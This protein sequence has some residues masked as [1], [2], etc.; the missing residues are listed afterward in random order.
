MELIVLYVVVL[1]M[2]GLLQLQQVDEFDLDVRELV[3]LLVGSWWFGKLNVCKG[4]EK[5]GLLGNGS[6]KVNALDGIPQMI[7]QYIGVPRTPGASPGGPP[8]SP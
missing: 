6:R 8:P 7:L 1:Y 4:L 3:L 5:W 2:L